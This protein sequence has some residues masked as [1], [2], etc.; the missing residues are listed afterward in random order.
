MNDF[1]FGEYGQRF[2]EPDNPWQEIGKEM[3]EVG[4]VVPTAI[5]D[6][7]RDPV[8]LCI[9]LNELKNRG[10]D[11]PQNFSIH[12]DSFLAWLDTNIKYQLMWNDHE[13]LNEFCKEVILPDHE[14]VTNLVENELCFVSLHRPPAKKEPTKVQSYYRRR[15]GESEKTVL[16]REFYRK[17]V[18]EN[19][20]AWEVDENGVTLYGNAPALPDDDTV[21]TQPR[22]VPIPVEPP[23]PPASR[24]LIDYFPFKTP[25]DGQME[26]CAEIID[27]FKRGFTDVILEGPTGCGKSV[28]AI[29]ILRYLLAT[30]QGNTNSFIATP[31]K[32]LQNQ[33]AAEPAFIDYMRVVKGMSA[34]RCALSR[35][36]S[37]A[38]S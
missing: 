21:F 10:G 22:L 26:T 17:G 35:T 36:F 24:R 4:V 29:T 3:T 7:R 16:V 38:C 9:N 20:D 27:A 5:F 30:T 12:A 6:L 14:I 11:I 18:D 28:L 23:K 33:Y 1:L 34:Y 37:P 32:T 2:A 25:R 19:G 31:L 13:A 15:P 8:R